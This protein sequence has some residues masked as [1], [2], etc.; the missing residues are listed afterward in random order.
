MDKKRE[1]VDKEAYNSE[2]KVEKGGGALVDE[3]FLKGVYTLRATIR[4]KG[5]SKR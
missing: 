4:H 2:Y 1:I 3:L 5:L